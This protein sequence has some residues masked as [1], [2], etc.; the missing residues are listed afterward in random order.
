MKKLAKNNIRDILPLT[1][2]QEGMLFHYLKDPQ[3]TNYCELLSLQISGV[4]DTDLFEKAWNFVIETNEM[5]RAMFRWEEVEDP[6]QIILK[7]YR[8]QPQY[9]DVFE[10]NPNESKIPWEEMKV[11]ERSKKFDLR[12]VPFRVILCKFAEAKYEMIISSHHILYDG[13]STGIILREFFQAYH[14]LSMGNTLIKPSKNRFKEFVKWTKNLCRDTA[15]PEKFWQEYLKG[16]ESPTLL[17]MK[18]KKPEKISTVEKHQTR[19]ENDLRCEIEDFARRY[20]VTLASILY[21]AWGILL[22]KYTLAEDVVFGIT[23]SGR[24]AKIQGIEDIV[25]L[26]INT[27]PLRV[28]TR[29]NEKLESLVCRIDQFLQIKEEYEAAPLVN[30]KEWSGMNGHEELFDTLLVLENYPLDSRLMLEKSRLSIDSCDMFEK[31]HY[32]LTVGITLFSGIE[33]T[34]SYRSQMLAEDFIIRMEEHFRR[35]VENIIKN[36]GREVLEIE[37]LSEGEKNKLLYEFNDTRVEFPGNKSIHELLEAQMERVPD[38]TGLLGLGYSAGQGAED[39]VTITYRELMINS[40]QLASQ[41]K[42]RGVQTDS[43]VAI[44]VERSIGMIIGIFAILKAGGAYLPIDPGYP[45]ERIDYMLKDSAAKLLVTTNS[46]SKEG[47][48]VEKWEVEIVLLEEIPG[49]L[50]N[51]THP[52]TFQGTCPKNSSGIKNV[53]HTRRSY[54]G[55]LPSCL[56]SPSNLIYVIYTSGSTGRPKG[57]LIQHRSLVNRLNWMQQKY[58]LDQTDT[59]LQKTP[60]TFDVSVWEIVWW[61][62]QGAKLCL[63]APGGEKDVEVIVNTI[64]KANITVIHFVPS[65]LNAFL[66]Y[67]QGYKEIKKLTS[68]RQVIASGEA[69]K[70]SQVDQFNQW[71]HKSVSARLA[72][73][74]GPT[75]AAIDVSSFDCCPGEK[76]D[77]IPIGKPINNIHLYVMDRNFNVQPIGIA[78]ELCI[79]GVGLARGYLNRPDLTADRFVLYLVFRSMWKGMPI[80]AP[81]ERIYRTGD[82]A[83]WRPDGNIEFHGRI[84]H[85]VKIRGFRIELGEIEN[86]LL[87]HKNVKET[88][89]IV[90]TDKNHENYLCA[91]FVGDQAISAADLKAYLTRQLPAYM[92]PSFFIRLERLP[93]TL[94]GKVDRK[95]LPEPETGRTRLNQTYVAPRTSVEKIVAGVWVQLLK[96]DQVGLNDN[97]FDLGGNSLAIIRLSSKLKEVFKRDVP[98]VTLFNYPTVSAQARYLGGGDIDL[99]LSLQ[100]TA[101]YQLSQSAAIKSQTGRISESAVTTGLEI[102]VIAMAGRFPGAD[103]I[104][105]FWDNLKNGIESISF[106]K[107]EE[108][109]EMGGDS[110]Q[111]QDPDFVKAK[112]VLKGIGDFDASFFEYTKPDA[113]RMDP[114]IRIF[115]E[116]AWEALEKAGYDPYSYRGQI[117]LYAGATPNIFWEILTLFSGSNSPGFLEQWE[118]FQFSNKDYLSTR[119][120]YKLNLKGPGVTVQTACSTSLVA[121]DMACEGLLGA[122]CDMALA[123]GVSVTFHD[124]TG[125]LYH[126]GMIFSVDG[127][128][129]AFDERASGLVNGNGIGI[130]VLK[131]LKDAVADGDTIYAVI[132]GTAVNNDGIRKVGYTAPSIAGQVEVIRKAHQRAGIAAESFSYIETHGTGTI[133]GDPIEVEAL[134]LAFDVSKKGFCGIGSV[135]TNIGHLDA[136]A[137]VAG[138][139]KTV[140][141]IKHRLLPPS[142]HFK[143]PNQQIDFAGSPFYVNTELKSWENA[144]FPLRAGVSSFG[145]GGTNAHVVLEEW[146]GNPEEERGRRPQSTGFV[147]EPVVRPYRLILLSA[148]TPSALDRM[149]EHL[150]E[151]FRRHPGINLDDAAYTLQVG[152]KAFQ[153]RKMTVGSDIETAITGLNVHQA[154]TFYTEEGKRPVVFMFSGQGAQYVNMGWGLYQTEKVFRETVDSSLAILSSVLGYDMKEILYPGNRLNLVSKRSAAGDRLACTGPDQTR[155][156]S[157]R[158]NRTD[159]AQPA[160]FTIE[161]A[162]AKLLISWGIKPFAMIGHSIGEYSAACLADVFSLEDALRL[163]VLRGRLMN[164]MPS[165]AMLGVPLPEQDL[166]PLLTTELSLAAVNSPSSCVV[167][168]S[169]ETVAAFEK[170][171]E[172]RGYPGRR[173]HTSHAFHSWMMEPILKEFEEKIKEIPLNKPRIPYVSNLTGNWITV[174]EVTE[175]GYWAKHLRGTVRFSAGVEA[176]LKEE[177]PLFIEIG[178]GSTLTTYVQQH[179]RGIKNNNT[180]PL[181]INMVRHPKE[182]VTDDYYLLKKIG[183]LWLQGVEIDWFAFHDGEKRHRIPLPAYPFERNGYQMSAAKSARGVSSGDYLPESVKSHPEGMGIFQRILSWVEAGQMK[184]TNGDFPTGIDQGSRMKSEGKQRNPHFKEA[185]ERATLPAAVPAD[186]VEQKLA[187][188]WEDILGIEQIDVRDSFFQLGGDSLKAVMV[189]S[190]IRRELDIQIP[191]KEFFSL[192]SIEGLARYIRNSKKDSYVSIDVMEKKEYYPLSPAQKRMFIINQMEKHH[193][194]NYN[195]SSKIICEGELDKGKM[196]RVFRAMIRRHESLR[197]S[198]RFIED[199]PVQELHDEVKLEIEYHDLV[200]VEENNLFQNTSDLHMAHQQ[201]HNTNQVQSASALIKA[202]IRP[203]DLSKTPLLR[204]AL[205]KTGKDRYLLMTDMHHIIMDGFSQAILTRDFLSMYEGKELPELKLQYKD[206]AEWQNFKKKKGLLIK[207]EEYW[208]KQFDGEIPVLDL[209]TDYVRPMVQSFEGSTV[210]FEISNEDSNTLKTLAAE[211]R[212]TLYMVLLAIYNILLSK[213][214]NK[215]D[216]IVGTPTVGRFHPD[217]DP[218]IGMF[219]NSLALRNFPATERTFKEFLHEVQNCTLGAFENQDYQFEDLV[220][221]LAIKR[222]TSR[223]PLFDVMFTLNNIDSKLEIPGLTLEPS[224][225]E[226]GTSKFDLDITAREKEDI[227]LFSLQYDTKLFKEETIVRF[228]AYFKNIISS[229]LLDIG[230]KISDITILSEE[231]KNKLLY[232]FNNTG[233]HYPKDKNLPELFA[234][235]EERAP[236]HTALVGPKLQITNHK[237]PTIYKSLITNKKIQSPMDQQDIESGYT[238]ITYSELNVKS[239][240]LAHLLIEQG[241]VSDAIVGIMI[242][243]CVEMVIGILAI[244]KA[245]GAYLPID[246]T[247]PQERIDYM[248]K[249]SG[250]RV[251][252]TTH[253]L[254]TKV[255]VIRSG[256]GNKNLEIVFL[257]TLFQ[258]FHPPI[259]P[260][261]AATGNLQPETSLAYIIYTSGSTGKPKGVMVEHGNVARLVKNSNFIHLC[262]GDRLLLTGSYVFDISTFEIWAPLLN[263]LS[264]YLVS[265][266]TILEGEE[267]KRALCRNRINIL[268]LV[269]QIFTQLALNPGGLEIFADLDYFLIGGDLVRPEYIN[270]LR[271]TYKELKI[272]HM[273]GPTENTTFSTYFPVDREFKIRIPIGKPISN[274][275]AYVVGKDNQAQ[276]I[277]VPGELYVGGDGIA[278]GY[279]NNPELTS[280]KFIR[281]SLISIRPTRFY[282][283]GDITR[284]LADGNIEFLGRIDHQVKTRGIRIEPGEIEHQLLRHDNIKE[285]IVLAKVKPDG[286]NYLCAY[287][288]PRPAAEEDGTKKINVSELREFLSKLIPEYMIPSY[289]I[290]LEHI[291]LNANG[292]VDRKALPEPKINLENQYVEPTSEVEKILVE[293][294]AQVLGTR[295]IGINDNFFEMG[296]DSINAIKITSKMYS[297]GYKVTLRDIFKNPHISELAPVVVKLESMA[298]QSVLSGNVPLTPPQKLF[299]Q[300]NGNEPNHFNQA[301]MFYSEKRFKEDAIKAIF[302][303]IQEHHD[304]LRMS[305]KRENNRI[306]Q[307]IHPLDYPFSL[308]VYDLK[309]QESAAQIFKNKADEIQAGI[310]IETGPLMKLAIFHMD[311][312]DRLLIVIHHLVIDGVSWR[313]LFDDFGTLY[314]QYEQGELLVLPAKTDSFKLWSETM[315]KFSTSGKVL[316]QMPFWK[317]LE[318]KKVSRIKSDFEV[319]DKRMKDLQI[320]SFNLAPEET[321]RLLTGVNHAFRTEINDILITALGTAIKKSFGIENLAISFE[322]HGREDISESIDVSR[323]IGWFTSFYPLVLDFSYTHDIARQLKEVKETLRRVPGK[324][325]G[326][327]ILKFLTPEIMKQGLEFNL[328]PQVTFNYLGQFDTDIKHLP[329]RLA[330]ESVGNTEG[331]NIKIGFDLEILGVIINNRLAITLRF[332]RRQY[333]PGTIGKLLNFYQ[334]ELRSIISYCS[335][336]KERVLTPSDLTYRGLSVEVLDRLSSQYDLEDIYSL[337]P[338]QEGMLFHALYHPDS[339]TY[340]DQTS[341]RIYKEIDLQIVKKSLAQ[342]FK[343]HDALRTVF[344]H[345]GMDYPL[346]LLLKCGKR[347]IELHYED[348][349][350]M[351]ER[352]KKEAFI[353]SFKNKNREYLFNISS[354][355][356]LRLVVLQIDKTEYE[357]IWSSLHIVMDGWTKMILISEYFE[358]YKSF[359]EN[360]E[361]QLPPVRFYGTY[362]KW[363]ENLDKNAMRHYWR[364]YLDGYETSV[365]V[366][367]MRNMGTQESIY[368][369][370]EVEYIVEIEKINRLKEFAVKHQITL[371]VIFQTVWAIILGKCNERQDVVFGVVVSGRP[372]EIEGVESMAGL[373]INTIPVR[374]RFQMQTTFI[375]LLHRVRDDALKT[376]PYHFLPLREIQAQ[377]A[378]KQNLL[379]HIFAFENYPKVFLIESEKITINEESAQLSDYH[380]NVVIE[381][382]ERFRILLGYNAEMYDRNFV[383]KLSHYIDCILG[384]ILENES[385]RIEDIQLSNDM[386]E[387]DISMLNEDYGEFQFY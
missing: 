184:G 307:K 66:E 128:C 200:G 62:L 10:N 49:F 222:D 310:D 76:Y 384:E 85:Q 178:P 107:D 75:E 40:G 368:R 5:L 115:H 234:E 141:A 130:V 142:L 88:V 148:K 279:L 102:A 193:S 280:G 329:F 334:E 31:T 97:F 169:H 260:L 190:K 233:S 112:G 235:Q 118:A 54:Q 29:A 320:M 347:E 226:S 254:T 273:Y 318:T 133:L 181:G 330:E 255:E 137:G 250:A 58:P 362:I 241:V 101:P 243:R 337:S 16:V 48:K 322:G 160:L 53:R 139:I 155:A 230:K 267:L 95:A 1:P 286:D 191:L 324:G 221:K 163:V 294:W 378:L 42:E 171:L 211:E 117:G 64:R 3:E 247:Y 220:S 251:L 44:M 344:I 23:V 168:G 124:K 158:M 36:P 225:D 157:A 131:R 205:I 68:L 360:R 84:D 196:E 185:G 365:G 262:A 358:I 2:M 14:D 18:E 297:A 80:T 257:E 325:V 298:D 55:F 356:L 351:G 386:L 366:P 210:N 61:A 372:P 56:Q 204:M 268:H 219:V 113:E 188:I 6:I 354:D 82:L 342:I 341:Y 38:N 69:L 350:G 331:E 135:K 94:N 47:E 309:G 24:A 28:Q 26:F 293:I 224:F 197:T 333:N 132:K 382:G 263:G 100:T 159:I 377:S 228:I 369:D 120:A 338:M 352:D 256:E 91:Y 186:Q 180:P 240:Q 19:F 209:P 361:Y 59:L 295:R 116:C 236:D 270:E 172:A 345:E 289:F 367:K 319:T 114:Q 140:L 357:F 52:I 129:R 165:G 37:F 349:S 202:F 183:E 232:D 332:N 27:L 340:L 9:V 380:F 203:F 81:D 313:I 328:V 15:K 385:A 383:E 192:Y 348:I 195:I 217:L 177:N 284:W 108:L 51:S 7:E 79:G 261:L 22:Q 167:S 21:S 78:G 103:N 206:Y 25:G 275:Y 138:F 336:R 110:T 156:I 86:Q 376:E 99:A 371:N 227:L 89:V 71:L 321:E 126:E 105:E 314:K 104:D 175:P 179:H 136:A 201:L 308:S 182:N 149:M 134:K 13:W 109:E 146:P 264:L 291:P 218:I 119:I 164:Q 72:N 215:D 299:F 381:P 387:V 143:Q 316:N 90:K 274:S 162:L 242:E 374:I 223:N 277:G 106:F 152:R 281:W 170:E 67:L 144:S 285:T 312:G 303:K 311:D 153:H 258:T 77:S 8:L 317:G 198:F 248:L 33:L 12:K 212:V 173:L 355:V 98:V 127:H 63:L 326:Y 229:V 290:Q 287:I 370:E 83:H 253:T 292:K 276:P 150:R 207:Q 208:L 237:L 301:V 265:Q 96:I 375:D 187:D 50:K 93:L 147:E 60:Y 11:I 74:Y 304:A 122:K 259:F 373:F 92:V 364:E 363:L 323:T 246:P 283:T 87:S 174:E 125:Y 43:I 145:I 335:A 121:I 238:I 278:R 282:K 296:G 245:G 176:L 306:I 161:Y 231:E 189:T 305:Y 154:K 73:L 46:L 111:Y 339:T 39:N 30:I 45:R 359:L 327:G 123:G 41:L 194:I 346:Q 252:V 57:T 239:D 213:V 4:V 266:Q 35:I 20:H 269:P 70:V 302:I 343:R 216:I 271:K 353:H 34:L 17:P 166:E 214:S 199:E 288:V 379:N 65:M 315:A 32:D 300:E 244:L 249:D 151:H 272:L